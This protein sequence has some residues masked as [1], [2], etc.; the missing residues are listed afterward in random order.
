MSL[1]S[2]VASRIEAAAPWD[3][4]FDP[5]EYVDDLDEDTIER[6]NAALVARYE[7]ELLPIERA[8]RRY[9]AELEA[10]AAHDNR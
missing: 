2:H 8:F 4:V 3:P 5:E 1:P 6:M 7:S 10:L 9:E